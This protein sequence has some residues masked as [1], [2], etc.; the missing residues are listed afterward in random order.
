MKN[1]LPYLTPEKNFGL[2]QT[3]EKKC[4]PIGFNNLEDIVNIHRHVHLTKTKL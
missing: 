2:S 3:V 1:I 4:N